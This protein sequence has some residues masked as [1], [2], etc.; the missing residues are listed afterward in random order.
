[1]KQKDI[2]G[3]PEK[4]ENVKDWKYAGRTHGPQFFPVWPNQEP[5]PEENRDGIV[6]WCEAGLCPGCGHD[7]KKNPDGRLQCTNCP[8]CITD[9]VVEKWG[10]CWK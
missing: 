9:E 1:M 7:V 2:L 3:E 10:N 6:A 5:S 4:L 8:L